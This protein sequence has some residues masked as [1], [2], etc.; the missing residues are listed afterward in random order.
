MVYG[1]QERVNQVVRAHRKQ[2]AVV[3]VAEAE[4]LQSLVLVVAAH[5]GQ[6]VPAVEVHHEQVAQV[7]EEHLEPAAL[8]ASAVEVHL[9]R[10]VPVAEVHPVRAVQVVEVHL[11]PMAS[12]CPHW[13]LQRLPPTDQTA[14]YRCYINWV[15]YIRQLSNGLNM[16]GTVWHPVT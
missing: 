8:A 13:M 9:A 7:L 1:H 12:S 15:H 14:D 3:L 5:H 10:A 16:A 4:R 6:V 2:V 11:E